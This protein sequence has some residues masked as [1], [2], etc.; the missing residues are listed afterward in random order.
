MGQ[1]GG[2]TA[3]FAYVGQKV[4][5]WGHPATQRN[6]VGEVCTVLEVHAESNELTVQNRSFK[7]TRCADRFLPV[8]NNVELE[9]QLDD[10]LGEYD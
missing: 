2:M 1:S 10:L 4:Y 8:E 7:E 9:E 3:E 5:Y 6:W